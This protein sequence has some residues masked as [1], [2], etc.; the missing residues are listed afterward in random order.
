MTNQN[1]RELVRA[2]LDD[3]FM[4]QIGKLFEVW[5]GNPAGQPERAATGAKNAIAVYREAMTALEDQT[6]G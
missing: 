6:N 1:E 3:A 4:K 2:A 5:C